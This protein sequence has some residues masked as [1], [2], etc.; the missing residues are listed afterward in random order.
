M[1]ANNYDAII[2]GA[3][4]GGLSCAAYLAKNNWKVLVLEKNNVPGG[5]AT[6]FKRGA[7]TFDSGLHMIEA[8]AHGQS[9]GKLFESCGVDGVEFIKLKNWMR[10]VFPGHDLRLP[11]GNIDEFIRVLDA[12]FPEEKEGIQNFFREAGKIY[13]DINRF[14]PQ[15]APMWQQL[16][17]FPLKYGALFRN[18]KKSVKQ[19]LDK[20]LKDE[21]LKA[22]LFANYGYFALPPSKMNLLPLFANM[23]FWL[24]GAYYPKGGDQVLTDA[25]VAAIKRK[26]GSILL[27][28]EVTSVN[29][30]NGKAV[31]VQTAKGQK[32]LAKNIIS[33]VNPMLTFQNLIGGDKVPAKFL[34]KLGK[35]QLS[36]SGF[37][38][39]LG[40]D[41][42]FKEKID[43]QDFEIIV[44]DTYDLTQDYA[45]SLNN[46]FEK[47]CFMITL[48]SNIDGSLA[49][50][51]KF[52][53]GLV[54]IHPFSYW[55]KFEADY[56][57]GNKAEYN[58]EKDRLAAALIKRAEK[59]IPELS[60]HVETIEIAT[61]LTLKRYSGN[62]N[63]A[64]YG[65]ANTTDQ[66]TPMD[67]ELKCPIKNLYLSSA[68]A[69]PGEGHSG[70]VICGYRV[71][72]QLVDKSR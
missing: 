13:E 20:H 27:G 60:K 17:T 64:M 35:M 49:K 31:G 70:T 9:M 68:W 36:D 6:S 69:F 71:A 15:T 67:R 59:I 41:E 47:A 72:K 43:K 44:S 51:G 33:N 25:F 56:K 24:E 1:S 8:A 42:T 21:K 19:L 34:A 26:N 53:A 39:F 23:G 14:M 28:S 52:V 40:L 4:L 50:D 30:E 62:P 16:P 29:V 38:V 5:Y 54:Q 32:Y 66:F 2:V 3:G 65:W 63:G 57:L 12:N 11:C 55:K 46:N 48:F 18:M 37:L 45:D 61:P 10:L 7:F 22:L 58:K